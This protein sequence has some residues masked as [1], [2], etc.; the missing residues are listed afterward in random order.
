[1]TA[2]GCGWIRWRAGRAFAAVVARVDPLRDLAVLTCETS[3][4]RRWRGR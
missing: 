1:M 3:A 4:C 2:T